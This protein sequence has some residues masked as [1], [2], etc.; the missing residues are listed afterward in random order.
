MAHLKGLDNQTTITHLEE[1]ETS[2]NT[3]IVS[4]K[5]IKTQKKS[6]YCRNKCFIIFLSFSPSPSFISLCTVH[7]RKIEVLLPD[8]ALNIF[9]ILKL[10]PHYQQSW[11]KAVTERLRE[12]ESLTSTQFLC[13]TKADIMQGHPACNI[14]NTQA[15]FLKSSVNI[16]RYAVGSSPLDGTVDLLLTCTAPQRF[17]ILNPS[18]CFSHTLAE[19]I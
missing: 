15:S 5:N 19:I 3:T 4:D 14:I 12:N 1:G 13:S 7:V 16:L 8:K 9:L 6:N 17:T 11:A 18:V 2:T 10:S